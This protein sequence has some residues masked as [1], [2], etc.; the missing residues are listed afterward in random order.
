VNKNE[1]R[2]MAENSPLSVEELREKLDA[3][4]PADLKGRSVVNGSLAR[5]RCGTSSVA[6]LR[7]SQVR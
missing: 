1:A 4:H 3:I 5:R 7:V 2:R 6:E